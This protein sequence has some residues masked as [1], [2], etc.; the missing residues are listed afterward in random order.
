MDKTQAEIYREH[1]KYVYNVAMRVMG[2]REDAEDITQNVFIKLF[3][4]MDAFR[5]ESSIKTY[6]YRMTVNEGIDLMRKRSAETRKIEKVD[7]PVS[8][9]EKDRTELDSLL[10]TLPEEQRIPVIM[11]QI[12]GF[13]YKEI[14]EILEISEGTVK[15]RINRGMQMLIKASKKE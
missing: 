1:S 7:K 6:L 15:S 14:A 11:S 2:S 12:T 13:S 10:A 5:G 9:K 4:N 8:Y 3:K